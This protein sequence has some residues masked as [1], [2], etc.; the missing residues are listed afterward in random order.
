MEL[1]VADSIWRL[2]RRGMYQVVNEAG[3]TA[4]L[5]ARMDHPRYVLC[6][7]SGSAE[8]NRWAT[9]FRIDY[10]D[11]E[12]R[13][14]V[15]V[16]ANNASAASSEFA[17]VYPELAEEA[18]DITPATYWPT[19]AP[20][21]RKHSHAWFIAFIQPKRSNGRPDWTRRSRIAIAV[22]LEFGGSGGR[23][24]GPLCRN[25]AELIIDRFPQY[26]D[27]QS[28]LAMEIE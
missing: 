9:Q 7:K 26:V 18:V 15:I 8:T 25:V 2:I 10:Q 11:G 28:P 5:F 23:S 4:R 19:H 14:S 20:K 17:R 6:G 1:P 12:Q 13:R 16:P 22:L 27:P 21:D 24:S 3:G